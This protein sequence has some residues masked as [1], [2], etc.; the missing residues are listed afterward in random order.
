MPKPLE[1]FIL[2][3]GKSQYKNSILKGLKV[4]GKSPVPD[5]TEN[6]AQCS[7]IKG[8]SFRVGQKLVG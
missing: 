4:L 7:N 3:T 8:N 2:E 5:L 6:L 1:Y